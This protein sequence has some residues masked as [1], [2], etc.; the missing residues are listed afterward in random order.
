[1]A[2]YQLAGAGAVIG[3]AKQLPPKSFLMDTIKV[4]V[5]VRPTDFGDV[6]GL[7]RPVT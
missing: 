1:M 6:A 3:A 4:F 5:R 7:G 2:N